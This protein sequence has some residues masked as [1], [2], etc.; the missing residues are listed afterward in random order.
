MK[1]MQVGLEQIE[2]IACDFH[3][4]GPT[5]REVPRNG[6]EGKFSIAYCV[7]AALKE[8]RVG[9]GE[10]ADERMADP[11][12]Q[13]LMKKTKNIRLPDKDYNVTIHLLDGR[14]LSHAVKVAKGDARE[15]PLTDGEV[16]E[17]FKACTR[18]VLSPRKMVHA[19]KKIGQMEKITRFSKFFDQIMTAS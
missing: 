8:G 9:L 6:L 18:G 17:K 15:N 13:E 14:S 7:A 5:L 3:L 12:I 11:V 16:A 2:S 19:V 4:D 10:F 1:E